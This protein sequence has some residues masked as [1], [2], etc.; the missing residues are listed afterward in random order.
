MKNSKLCAAM[1]AGLVVFSS[2]GMS[3]AAKGGMI[4]GG[5]GAAVGALVGNLIGKNTTGTLIGAGV[6]AAVGTTAGILIGKK[7]DKA[8][9]AAQ[10]AVGASQ[11]QYITDADGNP[12]VKVSFDNGILFAQNQTAIQSSAQGSLQKFA[13]KVLNVYTDCDVAI[14]GFASSEGSDATNLTISQNR[15]NAVKNYLTGTCKV[16]NAQIKKTTGFGENPSYLV[17]NDDGT[18]NKAASRRVEVL[19]YPSKAMID[20]ANAGTLK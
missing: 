15:A 18:E 12:A 8:K 5:S 11:V 1:M 19:L 20:A 9:A 17:M 4:G 6:G 13:E 2:C 10:A 14:L 3:N 16:S 7:M